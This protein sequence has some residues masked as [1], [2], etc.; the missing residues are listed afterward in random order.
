MYLIY[1]DKQFLFIKTLTL[2]SIYFHISFLLFTYACFNNNN[3]PLIYIYI[4]L[5]YYTHLY[6]NNNKYL[7]I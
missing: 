1:Y 6:N 7:Y 5:I 3:T 2:I 4:H